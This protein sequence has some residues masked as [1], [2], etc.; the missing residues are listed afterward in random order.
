MKRL[1]CVFLVT[2]VP[3]DGALGTKSDVKGP[4]ARTYMQEPAGNKGGTSLFDGHKVD[5]VFDG[6][7]TGYTEVVRDIFH[8]ESDAP[9]HLRKSQTNRHHPPF[10]ETET[11]MNPCTVLRR[12]YCS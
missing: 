7:V 12:L 4:N 8:V 1:S 6:Y 11:S 2:L 9:T 5:T 3:R 10:I